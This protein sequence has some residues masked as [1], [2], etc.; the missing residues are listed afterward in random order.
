MS[1][2]TQPKDPPGGRKT[3]VL[4]GASRGI[5][6]ATVMRF[7]REGWRIVTRSGERDA[8]NELRAFRQSLP[9]I[10]EPPLAAGAKLGDRIRA[11]LELL[12]ATRRE[13]DAAR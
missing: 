1:D 4:T 2:V 7:S 6:H 13:V 12:R 8:S 9:V 10:A 3:V 5:G 11:E